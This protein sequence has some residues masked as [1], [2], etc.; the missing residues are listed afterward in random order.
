MEITIAILEDC[1]SDYLSLSATIKEWNKN[2]EHDIKI[3]YFDNDN[4]LKVNNV[5][6]YNLIFSDIRLKSL[7]SRTGIDVCNDLRN[8]GYCNDIIFTT[9]FDE[10]VFEGYSVQAFSYLLKPI[11][12]EAL[13]TCMKRY[14]EI[15]E[16]KYYCLQDRGTYTNI[17]LGD[18]LFI[19]KQGHHVLFHTT[20]NIY[21]ER[22]TIN[23]VLSKLP[24]C[25]KLCHKS[26]I[27]NLNHILS[28]AGSDI[29]LTNNK[30]IIIGR[31]HLA[32][33]R[34]AI[35]DIT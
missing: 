25:F 22:S 32:D 19:E 31:S 27:V 34:N 16:K 17:K 15:H 4:I 11:S 13:T 29:H 6:K 26:Y 28:I 24:S 12:I 20:S 7:Q 23:T 2:E 18:V 3:D 1:K 33:I 14:L 8:K 35:M 10:Y 30:K 5:N 9:D 21:Y